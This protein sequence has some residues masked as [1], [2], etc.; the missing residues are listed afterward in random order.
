MSGTR[1]ASI[2]GLRGVVGDGIDPV[3]AAE[4]AAAY[5]SGCEPGPIVVSHDGRASAPV[6][7]P[8]VISG[9]AGAGRDAWLAGA[10]A[11]PTV[12]ILVR[13]LHAVGG[14]QISASHNP[15]QYNGIKFFQPRGMVLSP[16]QGREVLDRWRRKDF[17]WASWDGLGSVRTI[18]RPDDA[19]LRRVLE[20]VDVRAIRAR[21]FTV[22][23][24]ACHGAGGRLGARLLRE[25]GCRPIV[26]G[27]EPDGLYDHLPEPTEKNLRTFSSVVASVGAAVGFA[28]DPDADRL[29]IV[30]EAGRYIGEERTLA[31]AAARRL[32]QAK[33]PVVLNLSTSMIT[34]ELA[35]RAGCRVLRTP[36]GEINVVE[37][38]LA[39]DA[40]LG[41]EG[42][43]GV[44]DPRVGFVRDSLAGMAMVL[45]LLA[46]SD[47]PLSQWVDALPHFAMV[48]DQYPLAAGAGDPD[49]IAELWDR[50]SSSF[51]DGRTDRRDGLRLEWPDRWVHVRASNTEPIVR[52]I[53]E[54]PEE[55]VA[56]A[57]ADEVGLLV[58]GGRGPRP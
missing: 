32:E 28:Q 5:A 45:D 35:R 8:A 6:F 26:L 12:G 14:V 55:A 24:D 30:D 15:P 43:G 23:L 39:E 34:E 4:F 27:G 57:L 31:L 49:A 50:V 19:H 21:G 17:A 16:G 46:T 53:A 48:K 2:S 42:N 25:L 3:V 58:A 33:G 36:V 11:T 44:I 37:A 29:A 20:I 10:A 22:A 54:G 1:I 40:L 7:Y 47:R 38:M 9:I 41:G 18:E 51:P 52:V 56:R 13:E